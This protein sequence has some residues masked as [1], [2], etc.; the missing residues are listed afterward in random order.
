MNFEIERKFL[1]TGTLQGKVNKIKEIHQHYLSYYDGAEERVRQTTDMLSEYLI[2]TYTYT[3]KKG[4]GIKRQEEERTIPHTE[5]DKLC[6]G[7]ILGSI[8]K[9]RYCVGRWELDV[10][11]TPDYVGPIMVM[12]IEL[13]HEDEPLPPL[14]EGITIIEEITEKGEWKNAS[15]AINGFPVE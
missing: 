2:P 12:E 7:E 5:F 1:V 8:S 3:Y 9:T 13:A 10:Y 4:K 15:I 11:S 14:P 6:K